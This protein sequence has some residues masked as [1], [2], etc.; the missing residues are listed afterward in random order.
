MSVTGCFLDDDGDIHRTREEQIPAFEVEPSFLKEN[1]I[2][3]CDIFDLEETVLRLI[4]QSPTNQVTV[5][6]I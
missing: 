5:T 1:S 2:E 6:K 4:E 3:E